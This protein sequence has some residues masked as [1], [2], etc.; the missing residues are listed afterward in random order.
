MPDFVDGH[1]HAQLFPQARDAFLRS[2]HN[3]P[4]DIFSWDF[5]AWSSLHQ[6]DIQRAR[7]YWH[8]VLKID[9][10]NATAARQL[11]KLST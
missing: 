8:E 4:N 10:G 11:A 9:P 3:N 1:Q 5:A 2:A 7:E 6:G